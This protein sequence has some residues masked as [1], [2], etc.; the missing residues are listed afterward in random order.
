MSTA[1]KPKKT[2]NAKSTV[3]VHPLSIL[4]GAEITGVDLRE[5][6]N[7]QEVADIRAA[8]L[9]WKVVFFRGQKIDDGQQIAFARN[10]GELTQGHAVYGTTA[11]YPEIYAVTK[12]A[13]L[14]RHAPDVM[15]TDAV[16]AIWSDA[17]C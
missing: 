5:P 14:D 3:E 12:E 6:L 8:L 4:A 10:F 1:T 11:K 7:A 2:H 15:V 16:S 17:S 9:K 13:E